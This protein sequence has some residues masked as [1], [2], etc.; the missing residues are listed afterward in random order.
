MKSLNKVF[1]ILS[2]S[3]LIGAISSVVM[4]QAIMPLT[5]TKGTGAINNGVNQY[6]QGKWDSAS[7]HFQKA[8]KKNPRSAVA[9]Y[10]LAL[11]LN[12]MGQRE[13]ASHHFQKASE[14]GRMNSFIRNSR[15]L[16]QHLETSKSKR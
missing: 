14:L 1:V 8:L 13:K 3:L 12:K 4:A 11:A 15:I 6:N 16:K 5:G 10:N 2:V 9:H 7:S